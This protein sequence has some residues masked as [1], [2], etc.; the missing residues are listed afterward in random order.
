[1]RTVSNDSIQGTD[2]NHNQIHP[3]KMNQT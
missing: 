2:L 3:E 1:M